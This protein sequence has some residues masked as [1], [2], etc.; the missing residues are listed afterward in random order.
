MEWRPFEQKESV[1]ERDTQA[2]RVQGVLV[3]VDTENAQL[4]SQ[5]CV[6]DLYKLMEFLTYPRDSFETDNGFHQLVI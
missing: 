3:S 5:A 1:C 6:P 2:P 4:P